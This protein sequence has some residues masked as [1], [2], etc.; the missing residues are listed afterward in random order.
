MQVERK[1]AQAKPPQDR[2]KA[3]EMTAELSQADF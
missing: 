1:E 3:H 2:P